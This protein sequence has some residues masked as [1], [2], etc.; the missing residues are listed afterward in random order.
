MKDYFSSMR[1]LEK[2][3]KRDLRC[4]KWA[5]QAA[6]YEKRPNVYFVLLNDLSWRGSL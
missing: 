2:K 1:G 4:G 3:G 6:N 5:F